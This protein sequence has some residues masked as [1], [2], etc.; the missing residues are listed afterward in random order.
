MVGWNRG[1]GEAGKDLEQS[2]AHQVRHRT[3][4]PLEHRVFD[5]GENVLPIPEAIHI[6]L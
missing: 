6:V 1:G 2:A 3:G 4:V 5:M